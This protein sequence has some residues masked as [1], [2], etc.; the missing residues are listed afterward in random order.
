[1]EDLQPQTMDIDGINGEASTY[2]QDPPDLLP[3]LR[4]PGVHQRHRG[5]EGVDEID[6][7]HRPPPWEP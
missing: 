7:I 4:S 1:M 2:S 6:A 3:Q 5:A